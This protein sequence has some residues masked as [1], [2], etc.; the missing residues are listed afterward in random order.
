MSLHDNIR[1]AIRGHNRM[2]EVLAQ[3]AR[4]HKNNG[5]VIHPETAQEMARDVL[6]ELNLKWTREETDGRK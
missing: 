2:R 1:D 3:I 4:D 6:N 5:R